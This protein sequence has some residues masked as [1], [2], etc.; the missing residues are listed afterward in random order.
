[1]IETADARVAAG[2]MPLGTVQLDAYHQGNQVVIEV[3]DDG[4]GIQTERVVAKAIQQ[5]LITREEAERLSES[6][7]L[8]LIFAPGFSTA[9]EVTSVSGRGVG[10]DV[11]K[12]VLERLKGGVTIESKLGQGT[13]FLLKVPLT[14]AIIKALMFR[15]SGRLYAIPLTS[16]VEITRAQ[17]SE[18]HTVD[19]REVMRMREEV[20]PLI[21]LGRMLE[22]VRQEQKKLFIVVISQGDRKYGLIVDRLVGEEE[23]VIK[24]L[25]DH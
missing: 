8:D 11:V 6:E 21:R 5:N 14:L 17:E 7:I 3:A 20:L 23:L 18:V 2:K 10:M 15:V 16:V 9:E 1:G 22:G 19:H 13:R 24:A 4:A 25:D 12:T